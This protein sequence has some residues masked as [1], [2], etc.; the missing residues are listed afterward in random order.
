MGV[1]LWD[2]PG[3]G[4]QAVPSETYVQSMGLRYFDRVLIVTAGRFTEMEVAL[5]A[6][7]EQ[8]NVPFY[9]VRSKVDIDIWNNREDNNLDDSATLEQISQDFQQRCGERRVY[10]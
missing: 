3:A 6:E 8:H 5:Q 4:T 2:L 10:L 1:R 9:M 7:L